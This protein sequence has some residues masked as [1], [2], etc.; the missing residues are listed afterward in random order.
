M[1]DEGA[2]TIWAASLIAVM[3]A[4]AG[5]VLV[6]G[7]VVSARHRAASAAD[8]AALAAAAYGP[9]GEEYACGRARWVTDRMGMRLVE[10]R[11]SG[12]V[13]RVEVAGAI[14]GLADVT[15]RA[16]AGPPENHGRAEENTGP[17]AG[18]GR[19]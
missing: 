12:W 17:G 9:W 19:P 2:A 5:S 11:M 3:M 4:V 10:C 14:S 6:F 8:L 16:R 13:A 18:S 7:A 15:A 1:N